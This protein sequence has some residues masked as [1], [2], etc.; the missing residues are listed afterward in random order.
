MVSGSVWPSNQEFVQRYIDFILVSTPP[1]PQVKWH[2]ML[3]KEAKQIVARLG[4]LRLT[5][6]LSSGP[7]VVLLS[8]LGVTS[9]T[10]MFLIPAIPRSALP[11]IM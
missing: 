1:R 10:G 11:G 7:R 9:S 3:Y 5:L 4:A 2:R 6:S 8:F